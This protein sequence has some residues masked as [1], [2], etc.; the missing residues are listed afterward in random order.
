LAKLFEASLI[1]E[2]EFQ[3]VAA[4]TLGIVCFTWNETRVQGDATEKLFRF[5]NR[6]MLKI[7]T[8]F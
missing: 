7:F 8:F 2:K 5:F 3:L 1:D 4:V 6:F